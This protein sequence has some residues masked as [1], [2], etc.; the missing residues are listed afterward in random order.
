LEIRADLGWELEGDTLLVYESQTLYAYQPYS[1][2]PLQWQDGSTGT[3]YEI[4]EPSAAW[5]WVMAEGEQCTAKDSVFVAYDQPDIGIASILSPLTSCAQDQMTYVSLE[6]VNN[7][8]MDISTSENL[9]ATYAI[10]GGSSIRE[11]FNLA[12]NLGSGQSTSITFAE[13]FDFTNPG[14]YSIYVTLLYDKDLDFSNNVISDEVIIMENPQVEIGGGEDTIRT[15]L[16][17]TLEAGSGFASY[18]WQDNSTSSS[19]TATEYGL[20]WV[21]VSNDNGC[22]NRDSVVVWSFTGLYDRL[23]TADQIQLYPNPANNILNVDLELDVERDII[24]E[25]YSI[26][27]TL[28]F[29]KELDHVTNAEFDVDVHDLAPGVYT[30]RIFADKIPHTY[31]IVVE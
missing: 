12:E 11:D 21:E 15:S 30:L 3:T 14:T 25:L 31:M 1:S 6:I 2:L 20:Y 9:T 7:G 8:F 23:I 10:N 17:E 5:Y 18:L 19:Y 4:G 27:N 26:V 24:L 16:P 28:I 22:T 29:R 13:G